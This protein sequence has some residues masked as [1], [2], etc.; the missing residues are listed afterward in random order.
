M[1]CIVFANI[2]DAKVVDDKGELDGTGLVFPKAWCVVG[3]DV[4]Q[5]SQVF[6]NLLLVMMAACGMP[7]MPVRISM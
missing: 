7:Y 5:C 2:F 4:A 3:W 6:R 1:H